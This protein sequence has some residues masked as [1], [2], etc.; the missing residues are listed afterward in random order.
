[1]TGEGAPGHRSESSAARS[2][3]RAPVGAVAGAVGG[4]KRT[5]VLNVPNLLSALR[6]PLAAAFPLVDGLP[7]RMMLV[8]AAAGSDWVDGRLARATGRVTRAGALLDPVADKTFMAAVLVTLV[9]EGQLAAWALA[10]IL[11]RDIGVVIGTLA[12]TLRGARPRLEARRGGKVVTWLQFAALAVI[13]LWPGTGPWIAPV[14][15][16][17]GLAALAEYW[18][19]A[20]AA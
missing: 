11:L 1:M 18:R 8:L 9:V 20:R 4:G 19:R 6:F 7:M 15:G 13:L 16:L 14:V 10:L 3:D 5:A 12:L 2:R 17:A